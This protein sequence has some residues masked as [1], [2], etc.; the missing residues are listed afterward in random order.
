MTR[1]D[2][3]HIGEVYDLLKAAHLMTEDIDLDN[4]QLYGEIKDGNLVAVAALEVYDKI[5]LLRSVAVHNNHKHAGLG[6]AIVIDVEKTAS[7][8]GISN[9]YLLTETA[10]KFF[11]K[12]GYTQ[13]DRNNVPE[14][15]LQTTQFAE[16]CPQSAVCMTK[17][18][19][20]A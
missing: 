1:L 15:I 4:H 6:K 19:N 20:D 17:K 9:F 8:N 13:I 14:E 7:L 2:Q 16:L 10:D 11:N 5:A 3:T 18:L 12:L